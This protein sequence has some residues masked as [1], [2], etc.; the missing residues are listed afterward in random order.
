MEINWFGLVWFIRIVLIIAI[1]ATC[2]GVWDNVK[3]PIKFKMVTQIS[4]GFEARAI[5]GVQ[6]VFVLLILLGL[7][8]FVKIS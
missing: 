4:N 5:R 7:T 8:F 2:K 6:V 3:L 1:I